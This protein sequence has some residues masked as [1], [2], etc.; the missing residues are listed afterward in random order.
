M[1]TCLYDPATISSEY[2]EITGRNINIQPLVESP[3][4][5][6]VARSSSTDED[7]L[8]YLNTRLECLEELLSEVITA[9]SGETLTGKMR[10]F[11]GNS[12][13]SQQKGKRRQLLLCSVWC[14]CKSCLG[15][16]L[17]FP[18]LIYLLGRSTT[19]GDERYMW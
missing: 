17:C 8:C 13:A 15:T 18:M 4:L 16:R 7:Q 10:F 9:T 19:V 12:P 5:Y 11:H 3:T 1:V 6:T 2:K 14:Q